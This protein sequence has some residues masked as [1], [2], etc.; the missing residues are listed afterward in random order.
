SQSLTVTGV[1]NS[2]R[3]VNRAK[4]HG[5]ETV[6]ER[7]PKPKPYQMG[8]QISCGVHPQI[9]AQG[10][11]W[12]APAVPGPGVPGAS[13]SQREPDRGGTSA[14]RSCPYVAQHS[15]QVCGGTGGGVC[16]GEEC[17]SHCTHVWGAR[18]QLCGRAVLG[19]GV[20]CVDS[21]PG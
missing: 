12:A 19:A 10:V 4:C 13:P 15:A 6:H 7:L 18:A 8:M 17:D 16:E 21:G 1:E 5:K 14:A 3:S 20:F 11:V 2:L 9:S